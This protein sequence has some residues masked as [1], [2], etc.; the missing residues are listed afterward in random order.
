[1]RTIDVNDGQ[2][3]TMHITFFGREG[4][5]CWNRLVAFVFI[6]MGVDNLGYE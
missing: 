3:V 5:E 2:R 6:S 4:V 1:M